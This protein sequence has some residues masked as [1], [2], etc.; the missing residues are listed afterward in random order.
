M[1]VNQ[2]R[3]RSIRLDADDP[4]KLANNWDVV[5]IAPGFSKGLDDYYRFR[6]KHETLYGVT[7]DRAIEK[8]VGHVHPAFTRMRPEGL[9]GN[10]AAINEEMLARAARRDEV[11]ALWKIGQPYQGVPIRA[12]EYKPR[13]EPTAREFPPFRGSRSPCC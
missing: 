12:L 4:R 3:G 1:T 7:D 13:S 2:L 10:L 6:A 5:C 9:E 8:G 11:R